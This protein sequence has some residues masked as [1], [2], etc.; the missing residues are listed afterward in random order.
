MSDIDAAQP[1]IDRL[2]AYTAEAK[3]LADFEPDLSQPDPIALAATTL[4]AVRARLDRMDGILVDITVGRAQTHRLAI[5]AKATAADAWDAAAM[6]RRA[7][8]VQRGEEYYSARE[9]EAE[10]NLASLRE[11]RAARFTAE[12]AHLHDE[13]HDVVRIFHRRLDRLRNDVL[14]LLRTASFESHLER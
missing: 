2:N 6:K 11:L 13:A 3:A 12:L 8:P 10:A 5:T 9:R 4:A 7:A 14:A 1:L